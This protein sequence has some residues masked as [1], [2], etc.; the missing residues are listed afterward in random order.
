MGSPFVGNT[1]YLVNLDVSGT[2]TPSVSYQWLSDGVEISGEVGATYEVQ[3]SDV[4][5]LL[6]VRLTVSNPYGTI[7]KTLGY[8]GSNDGVE[9]TPDLPTISIKGAS[10]FSK[11][12]PFRVGVPVTLIDAEVFSDVP[13]VVSYTW[14]VND[15][16]VA[17]QPNSATYTPVA[18]DAGK[19]LSV[20]ITA[21]NSAGSVTSTIGDLD[22]IQSEIVGLTGSFTTIT[23]PIFAG[24]TAVQT[25]DILNSESIA[26]AWSAST[27][28]GTTAAGTSE[29]FNVP[30]AYA[31]GTLS[32]QLTAS[33]SGFSDIVLD[34][35]VVTLATPVDPAQGSTAQ[36]SVLIPGPTGYGTSYG[37]LW[38]PVGTTM[39]TGTSDILGRDEAAMFCMGL[40]RDYIMDGG[41]TL[42]MYA[43]HCSGI[44][45]VEVSA[46]GGTGISAGFV[47]EGPYEGEG[48]YT[49]YVDPT[50]FPAGA[51]YEIR[52]TAYPISGYTRS[53]RM[54]LLNPDGSENKVQIDTSGVISTAYDQVMAGYTHLG[55]NIVELTESGYYTPGSAGTNYRLFSEGGGYGQGWVEI[56]PAAGV[57]PK[58][59][60]REHEVS[61]QVRMNI[62]QYWWQGTQFE[63]NRPTNPDDWNTDVDE[64]NDG[65]NIPT[66]VHARFWFDGCTF[67]SN[68]VDIGANAVDCDET[69]QY[70][71]FVKTKYRHKVFNT[72]CHWNQSL[73]GPNGG[74]NILNKDCTC[75]GILRDINKNAHFVIRGHGEV[76]GSACSNLHCDHFQLYQIS[77]VDDPLD[78]VGVTFDIPGLMENRI[79]YG[80]T[81]T[82]RIGGGI[83]Q[84]VFITES[85]SDYRGIAIVH[86]TWTGDLTGSAKGQIGG[87][88]GHFVVIGNTFDFRKVL[89]KDGANDG[90]TTSPHTTGPLLVRG[91]VTRRMQNIGRHPLDNV[92]G[93]ITK[94]VRDEFNFPSMEFLGSPRSEQNLSTV[95]T[96]YVTDTS[97]V[98]SRNIRLVSGG[99]P[100]GG[101]YLTLPET[102]TGVCGGVTSSD[103][104]KRS[105]GT[106]GS[107]REYPAGSGYKQLNINFPTEADAIDFENQHHYAR[108]TTSKGSATSS[109]HAK[110]QSA[111]P[112]VVSFAGLKDQI[113]SGVTLGQQDI[114]DST[115]GLTLEF[116]VDTQRTDGTYPKGS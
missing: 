32:V 9:T 98:D 29:T 52:A 48:Y 94:G 30:A 87:T 40:P 91:N 73:D 95:L 58:I 89:L 112:R 18:S 53:A 31:G 84:P 44:S 105:S 21:L 1:L 41:F 63:N 50:H 27:T 82:D 101:D 59:D 116:R 65:L 106:I 4:D 67:Q 2:P 115:S 103:V 22:V 56:K 111:D 35:S 46:D 13:I 90:I 80:Y 97:S 37:S 93:G 54:R 7:I 79:M 33:A 78:D 24:N 85:G 64:R 16:E 88:A 86:N 25:N 17:T 104:F 74:G 5:A 75:V 108:I 15:V 23:Q 83:S 19:V 42:D 110:K 81:G 76:A 36:S 72:N 62:Y 102:C 14:K 96:W 43:F 57:I 8:D 49:V 60:L 12:D 28:G 100:D 47:Q 10:L 11:V 92:L 113:F 70:G 6:G 20:T 38:H 61:G 114:A 99:G 109:F 68:L 66:Q 107:F 26:Y 55:R 51:T 77:G 39:L 69:P 45:H 3:N 71:G 34:S